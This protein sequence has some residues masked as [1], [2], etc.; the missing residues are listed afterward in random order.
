MVF[1]KGRRTWDFIDW[2]G[3]EAR[4][5]GG[6]VGWDL[7]LGSSF[8]NTIRNDGSGHLRALFRLIHTISL[9]PVSDV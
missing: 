7:D 4:E 6:K 9:T 8:P 5:R 3:G 1:G 2:Y